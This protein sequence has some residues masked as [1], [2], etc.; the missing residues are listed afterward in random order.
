MN[1][2]KVYI[3]IC[4]VFIVIIFLVFHWLFSKHF[5]DVTLLEVIPR[6]NI[7]R[8]IEFENLHKNI[9]LKENIFYLND[10]RTDSIK[11]TIDLNF[12][13]QQYYLTQKRINKVW[14]SLFL[15]KRLS[16]KWHYINVVFSNEDDKDSIF[17]YQFPN[18]H[19]EYTGNNNPFLYDWF[20][21]FSFP[22]SF[23]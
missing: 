3:Y 8:T 1:R 12:Q 21:F 14:Y 5:I 18:E 23:F 2:K 15:E 17:L 13:E 19:I 4:T 10:E 20:S 9:F 6:K 22:L 11:L 16:K 7:S